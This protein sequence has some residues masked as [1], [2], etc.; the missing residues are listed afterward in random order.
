MIKNNNNSIQKL[1]NNFFRNGEI[2][3]EYTNFSTEDEDY[4]I[5]FLEACFKEISKETI[6]NYIKFCFKELLGNAKKANIK[7]LYFLEKKLN[8]E[9]PKDYKK[10]MKHFKKD[11]HYNPIKYL[12]LLED[13]KYYIK[14]ELKIQ[15][16]NFLIIVKNNAVILNEELK[17]AVEKIQNAKKFNSIED[18]FLVVQQNKEG[19]GLGIIIIMLMLKELGLSSNNFSIIKNKNETEVFI[20]IP[21]S[22]ITP[23]KKGYTNQIKSKKT[24]NYNDFKDVPLFLREKINKG[25]LNN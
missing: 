3:F 10:G 23:C 16:D 11:F 19:A 4:L 18:A 24:K 2:I 25:N 12:Y 21:L 1:I 8:I 5:Q 13:N 22:L 17:T 15:D 20:K 6:F 9:N 7:R 14:V